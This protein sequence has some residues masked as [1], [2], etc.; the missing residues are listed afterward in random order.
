MI[1]KVLIIWAIRIIAETS[2]APCANAEFPIVFGASNGD[3]E[4]YAFDYHP[5]YGG[6]QLLVAGMS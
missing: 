6:G 2:S 4:I 3:T 1:I 5:T